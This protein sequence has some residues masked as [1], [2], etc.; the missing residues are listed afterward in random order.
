MKRQIISGF[1]IAQAVLFGLSYGFAEA[2]TLPPGNPFYFMQ[3]SVRSLRRAFTFNIVSK[4]LLELRLVSER[5]ADIGEILIAGKDNETAIAALQAYDNEV[6]T[7]I[8]YAKGTG[9]DRVLLGVASVFVKHTRF[10]NDSLG[11]GGM[12]ESVVVRTALLASRDNLAHLVLE[13]FGQ[14]GHGAFRSRFTGIIAQDGD[15]YRELYA[16]DA[17][18]EL[19]QQVLSPEMTREIALAKEDMAITLLGKLKK[20]SVVADK[21]GSLG[22]DPLTRFYS[23]AAVRDRASDV[24]TKNVL[25][26]LSQNILQNAS[27][28]RLMTAQTARAAINYAS[29]INGMQGAKSEDT[30]YFIQQANK[31]IGDSAYDLAFQHGVLASSAATESLLINTLSTQDLREEVAL[32]KQQYDAVRVKPA[33][34]DKRIAAIADMAAKTAVAERSLARDMLAAI[35]EVKLVLA[36][37][38]N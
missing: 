13:V 7:L 19:I 11:N 37:L 29:F 4:A 8:E 33:F 6:A 20:G 25:T 5:R 36:L 14:N 10:F 26:L 16:L 32:L 30:R 28:A 21:I 9:D 18:A 35:R 27:Q 34:I 2:A 38:G 17:L 23:V 1:F 24:E 22:N 15:A 31:F 3:D 12:T